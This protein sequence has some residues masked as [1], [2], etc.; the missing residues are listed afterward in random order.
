VLAVEGTRYLMGFGVSDS[1]PSACSAIADLYLNGFLGRTSETW[2]EFDDA[3]LAAP[4]SRT[5]NLHSD[6]KSYFQNMAELRLREEGLQRLVSVARKSFFAYGYRDSSLDEIGPAARVGRGTLYRWFGDKEG[7][8]K[9][10][11]LHAAAEIGALKMPARKDGHP[12]EHSLVNLAMAISAALVSPIGTGLYRTVIAEADQYPDLARTVYQ[13]TRARMTAALA[14]VFAQTEAGRALTPGQNLW[15]A[16]QFITLAT[17]GNRYLS[18]NT[19]LSVTERRELAERAVHAF[20]Y[21]HRKL[22]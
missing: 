21:G 10:A 8:F 6:L 16:M 5:S 22:G 12:I 20:L 19:R 11:M 7:L 15:A 3:F 17:D 14:C 13:M 9:I 18:L 2:P 1:L 4:D